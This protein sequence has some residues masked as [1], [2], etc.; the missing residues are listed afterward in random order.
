MHLM[1]QAAYAAI[2]EAANRAA[3]ET[4]N[5]AATRQP[6]KQPTGQPTRWMRNNSPT[7]LIVHFRLGTTDETCVTPA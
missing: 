2:N 4:A 6:P 3:D 1:H 7:Y 5:Q